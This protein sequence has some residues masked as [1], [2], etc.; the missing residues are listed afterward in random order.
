MTAPPASRQKVA[1]SS[2]RCS[3]GCSLRRG[4]RPAFDAS[5]R[6]PPGARASLCRLRQRPD[7]RAEVVA[8]L[9]VAVVLVKGR[10]GGREQHHLTRARGRS[11]GVYGMLEVAA[12]VQP[13]PR[14]RELLAQLRRRL[15]DQVGGAAALRD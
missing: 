3:S 6:T 4:I 11:G 1:V 14:R 2:S 9:L 12:V 8:A 5:P 7:D 15:P 10:A 13:D